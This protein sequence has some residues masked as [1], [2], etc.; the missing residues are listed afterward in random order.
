M[1]EKRH[2]LDIRPVYKRADSCAAEFAAKTTYPCRVSLWTAC[3]YKR[4]KHIAG[5]TACVGLVFTLARFVG[6]RS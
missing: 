6:S 4:S 5:R 1:R 2:A 3:P